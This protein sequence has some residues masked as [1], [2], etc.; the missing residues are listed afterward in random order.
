MNH[1]IVNWLSTPVS[2]LPVSK[3]ISSVSPSD[4]TYRVPA[5]SV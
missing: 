5:L 1:T 2:K 3:F 4:H